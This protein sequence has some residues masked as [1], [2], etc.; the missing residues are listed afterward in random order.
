MAE[1][2]SVKTGLK[3][4]RGVTSETSASFKAFVEARWATTFSPAAPDTLNTNS[5]PMRGYSGVR[6]RVNK[7]SRGRASRVTP[8]TTTSGSASC[9]MRL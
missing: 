6:A 8:Q 5:P 4:S 1:I 7:P 3:V 9:R 2:S